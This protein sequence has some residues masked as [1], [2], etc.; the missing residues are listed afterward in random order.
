M[1]PRFGAAGWLPVAILL[2]YPRIVQAQGD[3]A[4]AQPVRTS[5][6]Y[7]NIGFVSLMD[8]GWSSTADVQSLQRGDH[9][10]HVRGFS[11]PNSELSLDGT[12]DPYFKGFANIVYKLEPS[13]ETDVESI[14][15]NDG[16]ISDG[17]TVGR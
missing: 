7:M 3:T 2:L 4:A 8:A 15:L 11:I 14:E 5:G 17:V 13:A 1:F 6:A 16:P 12:V 10:P 9:D